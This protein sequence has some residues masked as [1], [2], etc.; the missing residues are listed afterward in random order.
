M[1][2]FFVT[3]AAQV[4][5]LLS[6]AQGTADIETLALDIK[7]D[8]TKVTTIA[9][10]IDVQEVINSRTSN[11]NHYEKVWSYS[12]YFN[13]GFNSAKMTPKNDISLGCDYNNG[14]APEFKSDWGISLH[15]GHNYALHKRPIADI[16]RFNID[17]SYIDLNLNHYKREKG[18]QLYD[19]NATY[20]NYQYMPWCMQKY[21]I[22]YGMA[23]GP[24]ITL[25]P[26]MNLNV[27]NLHFL[28]L[29]IYY[30]IGYAVSILAMDNDT[31][32]DIN[33][34]QTNNNKSADSSIVA[35]WGHGLTNSFGFNLSWRFI[36]VGYEVKTGP[37]NYQALQKD[38]YGK[39]HYKFNTTTG[40]VF[41]EIRY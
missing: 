23:L 33:P 4:M 7:E 38:D 31:K 34:P 19:S 22:N 21:E 40:R 32:Y 16:L 11:V 29:N 17:Y 41:L 15:L 18:N 30:H 27:S 35:S 9:D 14:I 28:K 26:F 10:I 24:S 13:I 2:R 5:V 3:L 39:N 8:T 6:F 1:K 36:G 37:L 20:G 25:A 12:S